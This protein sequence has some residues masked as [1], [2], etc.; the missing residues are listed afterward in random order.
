MPHSPVSFRLNPQRVEAARSAA[1]QR[2]PSL[3][4][5]VIN[6]LKRHLES[7]T[8]DRLRERLTAVEQS[9][10]ELQE[11]VAEHVRAGPRQLIPLDA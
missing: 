10:R 5:W 4:R 1:D 7:P 9:V 3:A 11:Y 8:E 2:G 6:A